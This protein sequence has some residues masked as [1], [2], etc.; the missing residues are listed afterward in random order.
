MQERLAGVHGVFFAAAAIT[1]QRADVND[2]RY[3]N[4]T[5]QKDTHDQPAILLVDPA[6]KAREFKCIIHSKAFLIE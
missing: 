5:A 6:K 3:E 1:D 2:E 4:Q